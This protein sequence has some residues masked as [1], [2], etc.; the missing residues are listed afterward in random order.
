VFLPPLFPAILS[1]AHG[2]IFNPFRT[3]WRMQ[4]TTYIGTSGADNATSGYDYLYGADGDDILS[5]D[6][7]GFDVIEGGRG[8]DYMYMFSLIH[9]AY[10]TL[11]GGDGNDFAFG[12]RLNDFF[13]GG[14]G[15]D[16][17]IGGS[18]SGVPYAGQPLSY[19]PASGDDYFEGGQ[20]TDAIYAYDGNDTIYGGDGDDNN[21]VIS[22]ASGYVPNNVTSTL[23][24]AG[25]YGG[26]G[27]DFID[28]G[29]GNDYLDGGNG[30][31]TLLGGIGN[32]TLFGGAQNDRLDGGDGL[33]VFYGG[34]GGDV[35]IG[36]AGNDL[37]EVDDPGDFVAEVDDPNFGIADN[38]YAYVDYA[39]QSGVDNLIML[40]GNQTY[41]IGNQLDNIIIG[42][43]AA[44][45]IE[46]KA[47]YD[48]LTGGGGADTFAINAKWGVDVITDFTA[49]AGAT[50]ILSFS[51]SIFT[52]FASVMAAATQHGADTWISGSASEVVVLSNVQKTF[53]V[54]DDFQFV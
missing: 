24:L 51:N 11:Y 16:L 42:N 18:F 17:L 53:L 39:M 25:L 41:G 37:Y 4:M 43:G 29:A 45:Y 10:G 14:A 15:N 26:D 1:F 19:G 5:A 9:T 27:I 22:V 47:G 49:G 36:G 52:N 8:D 46:G 30:V 35:M 34:T 48:T 20:G 38:V 28:G 23:V 21:T 44:N 2:I 50:D 32:D 7:S 54:I 6:K 40:Y 12:E 3:N 31:D 13:Y 33:D